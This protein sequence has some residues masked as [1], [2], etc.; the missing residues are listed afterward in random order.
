MVIQEH[1]HPTADSLQFKF[2]APPV[3]WLEHRTVQIPYMLSRLTS[4][5]MHRAVSTVVY[6]EVNEMQEIS[7]GHTSGRKG[8]GELSSRGRT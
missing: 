3:Y 6:G 4:N 7:T 1:V 2:P 5:E 8:L